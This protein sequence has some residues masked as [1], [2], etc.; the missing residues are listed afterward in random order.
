M[1]FLYPFY[2]VRTIRNTE[3]FTSLQKGN[4]LMFKTFQKKF[5]GKERRRGY[6]LL[7]LMLVIVIIVIVAAIAIPSAVYIQ[8][9]L[10]FQ[11]LND[12]AKTIFL[13]AQ[14]NLTEMRADGR[15]SQ[16]QVPDGNSLGAV[17]VPIENNA[18][19]PDVHWSSE[20]MY[21]TSP[22]PSA[23]DPASA[24]ISAFDLV[25][26]QN[27]VED[28]LRDQQ[29]LIEYNPYTGNVFSVFYSEGDEALTYETITRDEAA[30]KEKMIGYYCGSGLSS[31][32]LEIV[33]SNISV[34]YINDQEGY[35]QVRVPIPEQYYE[36]PTEFANN[37]NVS[38]SITGESLLQAIYDASGNVT[39]SQLD[40]SIPTASLA[41]ITLADYRI[42]DGKTVVFEYTLDSL[43]AGQSFG[44]VAAG[45]SKLSEIDDESAFAILPGQNVRIVASAVFQDPSGQLMV[46]PMSDATIANPM[47]DYLVE[48]ATTPGRYVLAVSNG[49]NLQNLNALAPAVAD[50]VETVLFTEDIDWNETVEHY[51]DNYTLSSSTSDV[52]VCDLPY[53][54]PIH[55]GSLF[56]TAKFVYPGDSYSD[57]DDFASF[58]EYIG[59]IFAELFGLVPNKYIPTLTDELDLQDNPATNNSY[60]EGHAQ[61]LGADG[62]MNIYNININTSRYAYDSVRSLPSYY[63]GD[64]DH[65]F[66]GLFAYVNTTI[67]D[68]DLV[69]PRVRGYYLAQETFWN[70]LSRNY[71]YNNPATGALVGATGYNSL[72]T[73]CGVYIDNTAPGYSAGRVDQ[74]VYVKGSDQSWYGVSGE[75]AVGGL[76]G[77]AK[78]H[79]TIDGSYVAGNTDYLAFS[80]CFAA[81]PVS[82]NMRGY[83]KN[84][85]R[86]Y[87]YPYETRVDRDFGY[88]NGIGGFIGNS[89]LTNFYNCYASGSVMANNCFVDTNVSEKEAEELLLHYNG[90]ISMGA[91]GFV[92]TSHG[93]H[94]TN[95]FSTGNIT[96]TGKWG[97]DSSGNAYGTEG[98]GAGGFVG[99]MSYDE[100]RTFGNDDTNTPIAQRTVFT[101]CYSIGRASID[102]LTK[103]NFSGANARVK[104]SRTE[105]QNVVGS[106][107]DRYAATGTAPGYEDLY[108]FR[109]SYYL[110]DYYTS[111][112]PLQSNSN[113]C[114]DALL[115]EDLVALISRHQNGGWKSQLDHTNLYSNGFVAAPGR[116]CVA[117][118]AQ[119]HAYTAENAGSAYPFPMIDGMDYYGSWPGKPMAAGL[120]YY[121]TYSNNTTKYYPLDNAEMKD[122]DQLYVID[123]GYAIFTNTYA[124][125]ITVNV[126]GTSYTLTPVSAT[127]YTGG[128]QAEPMFLY[129]LPAAALNQ[130]SGTD[131]YTAVSVTLSVKLSSGQQDVQYTMYFNPNAAMTQVN[132]ATFDLDADQIKAVK[133]A[134]PTTILIRSARQFASLG[135]LAPFLGEGVTC[136]QQMNIDVS[137]YTGTIGST[138]VQVGTLGGTYTGSGGYVSQAQ[139]IGFVPGNGGFFGT[140]TGTVQ[141]LAIRCGDITMGSADS[142]GVVT[143]INQGTISNVDLV[144]EDVTINANSNA[145]LLAGKNTGTIDGCDVSANAVILKAT[146]AGGLAGSTKDGT[147]TGCTVTINTLTAQNATYAGGFV[148]QAENTAF[149]IVTANI[150]TFTAEGAT[151]GG[152]AGFV[153]NSDVLAPEISVSQVTNAAAFGG[154]AGKTGE[155]SFENAKVTLDSA[156]ADVVA[157]GFGSALLP[158]VNNA[159]VY[160]NGNLTGQTAAA[161]FA[162]SMPSGSISG[163]LVY[164]SGAV[165]A[166]TDAAGFACTLGGTVRGCKVYLGQNSTVTISGKNAAGFAVSSTATIQNAYVSGKAGII[167]T[168]NAAG[169]IVNAEDGSITNVVVT[170]V[171]GNDTG[172][173]VGNGNQN[174]QISGP[175]AAGFIVNNKARLLRECA[176][177]GTL[178]GDKTAGFVQVNEGPI[179]LCQANVA[180]PDSGTAFIG[181]NNATVRNCYGWYAGGSADDAAGAGRYFG[182]FFAP[183]TSSLQSTTA[184]TVT[185]F[186]GED[187]GIDG[188]TPQNTA[189]GAVTTELLNGSVGTAWKDPASYHAYYYNSK[190]STEYY[191][192]PM[193]NVHYGDWTLLPRYAYGLAYY[194]VIDGQIYLQLKDLSNLTPGKPNIHGQNGTDL[195]FNNIPDAPAR[196]ISEAGYAIL[197]AGLPRLTING[198]TINV[199]QLQK[200]DIQDL[201]VP[202]SLAD[203]GIADIYDLYILNPD[204]GVQILT[205]TD[206]D[207]QSTSCIP[208]F[209]R[210]VGL[211][212]EPADGFELRTAEQFASISNWNSPASYR[213]SLDL[214]LTSLS[215]PYVPG[216][217]VNYAGNSKTITAKAPLFAKVTGTAQQ[218]VISASAPGGSL[219]GQN[220]GTLRG[221]TVTIT[222]NADFYGSGGILAGTNTGT[223]ENCHVTATAGIH[224]VDG[225]NADVIFGG[226]A[227]TNSGTISGSSVN[228]TVTYAGSA[229]SVTIGALV[230]QM[231]GGKLENT[232]ASGSI[233]NNGSATTAIIGGAVGTESQD[234]TRAEYGSVSS[235]VFV[236]A[237]W[238][239]SSAKVESLESQPAQNGPVGTF[240][241]YVH[242]GRFNGCTTSDAEGQQNVTF[243]FLGEIHREALDW[244]Q[245]E[246]Q[247]G[248][249]VLFQSGSNKDG[250]SLKATLD[251]T[252]NAA[253]LANNAL[254][255]RTAPCYSF[256]AELTGCTFLYKNVRHVQRFTTEQYFFYVQQGDNQYDYQAELLYGTPVV[257]EGVKYSA[258]TGTTYYGLVDGSYHKLSVSTASGGMFKTTY[259]ITYQIDG[260]TYTYHT[261]T[262]GWFDDAVY[263]D[264]DHPLYTMAS[265]TLGGNALGYLIVDPATGSILGV[266]KDN[267]AGVEKDKVHI[268]GSNLT[269]NGSFLGL[270]WE[271]SSDGWKNLQ[272]SSRYLSPSKDWNGNAQLLSGSGAS[273][274]TKFAA[275]ADTAGLFTISHTPLFSTYY[276]NFDGTGFSVSDTGSQFH[277]YTVTGSEA[278]RWNTLKKAAESLRCTAFLEG[279]DTEINT[280]SYAPLQPVSWAS[281]LCQLMGQEVLIPEKEDLTPPESVSSGNPGGAEDT[282]NQ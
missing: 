117:S 134:A 103:E 160:V 230:G 152:F 50:K 163:V 2:I 248:S 68:L 273:L 264:A 220:S 128:N 79:R 27:S 261:N 75:G 156:S 189:L 18:G 143:G 265:P 146:N 52:P 65:S 258:L 246:A 217:I 126:G 81:V 135:K 137:K 48:S 213:Q 271:I 107:Y 99:I 241:G 267:N 34:S 47:F 192:Y 215:H 102:G 242:N 124:D 247:L 238:A 260:T 30:R 254:T 186:P 181:T 234:D 167:G 205:V 176:A 112:G 252:Y 86:E 225:S 145:G 40:T 244:A 180:L 148:G 15:I 43:L 69:N 33:E 66:T 164:I 245:L 125:S 255:D 204:S 23:A 11:Q 82:G 1:G 58:L 6:T 83:V 119:T 132:P 120:A 229:T 96:A 243:Q 200:L 219:F 226:L 275:D 142:A 9:N 227:G 118:A 29:I 280:T 87:L 14:A 222:E 274:S 174:L 207:G 251:N 168:E 92:G 231:T 16:L 62:G 88:S 159:I 74:D 235:T 26:P 151:A 221:I 57:I 155:S 257:A 25:L 173:Y 172:A 122:M 268:D 131:F 76:V 150:G 38:L 109:H 266:D 78:S 138:T 182:C 46:P 19:F 165:N 210:T 127:G 93:T 139:L 177:L 12:Y 95:C 10:E 187:D 277:L 270:G 263:E 106:Y 44:S 130:S 212:A 85:H 198:R 169:F 101:D 113:L 276:L 98:T 166:Q 84:E 214:D 32:T 121:E 61:I 31:S 35:V 209:A 116:W 77:Y 28:V 239:N 8:G 13:A 80:N 90:R 223:I 97:T 3:H 184:T 196:E 22:V 39:S 162:G 94:Y 71:Y 72:I 191:D 56:G 175:S 100:T 147:V 136:I 188:K 203:L 232:T 154:L 272:R 53:F 108:I 133:P 17:S 224:L 36:A 20:Y 237:A 115:Y 211:S 228:T 170:P 111:S 114:A 157:G 218:M 216:E 144:L 202:D 59:S 249:Q 282:T 24:V 141:D 129:R 7:E 54:V 4:C 208:H 49:R 195:S 194:E 178:S 278:Y 161:G 262:V 55:N 45:G 279:S 5:T 73:G 67:T 185:L 240:I 105:A 60:A 110:Y 256:T 253:D 104:L 37:L 42:P 140:V 193:F 41:P 70:L 63:V 199:D 206:N 183:L 158:T 21:C 179:E 269:V 64:I 91:G 236:D 89:Q 171:Y 149:E 190:L 250:T 233:V 259:T 197:C 281:Q 123:D 51:Q 153:Q 201:V